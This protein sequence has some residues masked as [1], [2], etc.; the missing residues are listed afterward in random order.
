[1]ESFLRYAGDAMTP[2]EL[3]Q[4]RNAIAWKDIIIEEQKQTIAKQ[5]KEIEHLRSQLNQQPSRIEA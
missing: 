5:R 1:M 2:E 3:N 4:W